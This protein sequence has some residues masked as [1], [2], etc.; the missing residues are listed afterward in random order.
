MSWRAA[1]EEPPFAATDAA[2]DVGP[3]VWAGPPWAVPV[4]GATAAR[5]DLPFEFSLHPGPEF[6]TDVGAPEDAAEVGSPALTAPF[7]TALSA[8]GASSGY[9]TSSGNATLSQS[10]PDSRHLSAPSPGSRLLSMPS[11]ALSAGSTPGSTPSTTP[12]STPGNSLKAGRN[13]G[14]GRGRGNLSHTKLCRDRLNGMFDRLR[15][16]LPPAPAGVEVKHKAQVLDYAISVL[17][18]MVAR[19]AELE[20]ELAVSSNEATMAWI[21]RLVERAPAFPVAATEVMRVF[22]ARRRWALAELWLA[23]GSRD[24]VSLVFGESVDPT[25]TPGSDEDTPPVGGLL[26]FSDLSRAFSFAPGEGVQGRVW[27]SMRPEWLAG[28][29]DP[30]TF[31]RADLARRFGIKTC[32]AVPVTVTGKIEAVVCFYD[33]RH[34]PYDSQCVELAVR[35]T[36]ALGNTT[37][38]KRAAAETGA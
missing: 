22:A 1:L 32:L 20:V 26:E 9:A 29:G 35:L 14:K 31:A 37:G 33:T 17:K 34:R 38:G 4:T 19:T 24:S 36:W 12:G 18:G 3:G 11:T 25:S 28:L 6:D 5:D 8:D 2:D 30:K 23:H 7:P 27:S 15:S 21:S 10:V 16:T 13:I